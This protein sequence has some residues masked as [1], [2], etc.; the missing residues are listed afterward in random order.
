MKPRVISNAA[1]V[2]MHPLADDALHLF[3]I[4]MIRHHW[5]TELVRYN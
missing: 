5:Y 3:F 4:E 1:W 2:S